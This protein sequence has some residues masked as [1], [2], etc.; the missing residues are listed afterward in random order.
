M[1]HPAG[2]QALLHV[3]QE[4]ATIAWLVA[5]VI[6]VVLVI[7][8]VLVILVV[9]VI[10]AVLVVF[11]V[12][13]V[14]IRP[15][16]FTILAV[17]VAIVLSIAAILVIFVVVVVM[18]A[19]LV[20][21][22]IVIIVMVVAVSIVATIVA[23]L[24]IP[25]VAAVAVI[26]IIVVVVIVVPS[27]AIAI[28]IVAIATKVVVFGSTSNVAFFLFGKVLGGII[29]QNI[30]DTIFKFTLIVGIALAFGNVVFQISQH[31][32]LDASG[33]DI[34]QDFVAGSSRDRSQEQ[35]RESSNEENDLH[36]GGSW[37]VCDAVGY[38][39]CTKLDFVRAFGWIHRM[40]I[41]SE[42]AS[43]EWE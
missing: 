33:T 7:F 14:V 36:D 27:I 28:A 41:H 39:R 17:V 3:T 29:S 42:G 18:A 32:G 25:A 26:I 24:V 35:G 16:I 37:F 5:L 8:V 20:V 22:V 23:V 12:V 9:L 11:V 4:L 13:A 2:S 34:V 43:P 19:I 38:L 15:V 6:L 40:P 10:F 1:L 30:L 31:F 21:V